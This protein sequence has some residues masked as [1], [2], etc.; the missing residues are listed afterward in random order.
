MPHRKTK[1]PPA[2]LLAPLPVVLVGCGGVE[3]YRRNLITVAWTGIVNSA[4]AMLSISVRPERYSYRILSA[5]GDFTVNVPRAEMA[6]AVDHCGVVSGHDEDK[7][8]A[9]HLTPVAAET[10]S[11]PL[12]AECPL[13]LECRTV[14][15]IPLGSHELFLAKILAVQ[16]DSSLVDEQGK[17]HLEQAGLLGYAHG[18]YYT[19]GEELGK[20]GFSVRR[21]KS[22]GD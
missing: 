8:A 19:L 1:F 4:P 9:M 6:S 21:K 22:S 11:A 20:F 18:A 2:T 7:F 13:S 5:I 17:F 15:R 3:H 14:Q 10:V 16:V 12:V